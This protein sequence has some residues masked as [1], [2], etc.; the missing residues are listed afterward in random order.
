MSGVE[1]GVRNLTVLKLAAIARALRTESRELLPD[2][3]TGPPV[4]P[5]LGQ[6]RVHLSCAKGYR[7][8]AGPVG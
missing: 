3:M 6:A 5:A 2:L 1:R 4:Q 7:P 8:G